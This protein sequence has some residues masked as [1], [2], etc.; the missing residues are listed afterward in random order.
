MGAPVN[1]EM[2]K[3]YWSKIDTNPNDLGEFLRKVSFKK[4]YGCYSCFDLEDHFKEVKD[5]TLK[6]EMFE[7]SFGRKLDVEVSDDDE[8][9]WSDEE[10]L[11]E[12]VL[13]YSDVYDL[14]VTWYWDGDGILIFKFDGEIIYNNDCKCGYDWKWT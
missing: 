12:S 4:E 6:T 7:K 11:S 8:W 5:N 2:L 13:R 10:V 9:G 1:K 3:N 14:Y